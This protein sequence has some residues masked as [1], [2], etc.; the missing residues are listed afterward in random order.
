MFF[1]AMRYVSFSSSSIFC[2]CC[3]TA[4]KN[5]TIVEKIILVVEEPFLV[6]WN[7]LNISIITNIRGIVF[8]EKQLIQGNF[9]ARNNF[10]SNHNF[11]YVSKNLIRFC[12][13]SN[14]LNEK[15]THIVLMKLLNDQIIRKESIR[16]RR[17]KAFFKNAFQILG[18]FFISCHFIIIYYY[19]T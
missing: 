2:R 17:W 19:I 1:F 13:K 10:L 12:A 15:T 18:Q 7:F 9:C 11:R 4:S 3:K 5:L 16:I 8:C 14:I 6:F